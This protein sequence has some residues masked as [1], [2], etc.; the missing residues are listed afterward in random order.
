MP[1]IWIVW[2]YLLG[3]ARTA[4]DVKFVLLGRWIF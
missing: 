3:Q 1:D 2:V 4:D